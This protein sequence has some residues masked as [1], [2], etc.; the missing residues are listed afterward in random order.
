[1]IPCG[2]AIFPI[3]AATC[4]RSSSAIASS[5]SYCGFQGDERDDR[6]TD[7]VVG[8]RHDRGLGDLVVVDERRFDLEGGETVTGDVHH[9]VDPS[10]EPEEP[11]LVALRAVAGDVDLGPVSE[12]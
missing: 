2:R 9:V 1:M 5:P 12:K 11:F 6:L 10:Q 7:E 4:S 8:L 3:F